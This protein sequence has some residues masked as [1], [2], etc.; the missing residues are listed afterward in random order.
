MKVKSQV[1]NGGNQTLFEKSNGL[2]DYVINNLDAEALVIDSNNIIQ[3]VNNS[4]IKRNNI[5][6]EDVIGRRCYEF[7]HNYNKLC[8]K[9][10]TNVH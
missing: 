1:P 10:N 6:R 9:K 8:L 5:K 4:L 2:L 3:D 7:K